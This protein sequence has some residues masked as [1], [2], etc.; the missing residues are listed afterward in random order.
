MNVTPFT[1]QRKAAAMNSFPTPD[2][3]RARIQ[4]E[5]GDVH[6]DSGDAGQT[7]V[8]VVPADPSDEKDCRDAEATRVTFTEGR[9]EVI[10]P[11]HRGL[12]S[13]RRSGSVRVSVTLPTGSDLQTTVV[14]G[15]IH[16]T[17]SLG[18]VSAKTSAGDVGLQDAAS[19]DLRSGYG[20]V[21]AGHIGGD[22]RCSTGSGSIHIERADAQVLVKNSNGDT[23]VGDGGRS[24][25]VKAANGD[26]T[27]GHAHG[28]LVATTANGN[29]RIGC[30]ER[31]QVMLRTGMGRIHLGIPHG[32][33]ARLDLRTGYGTVS[34]ELETTSEPEPSERTIEVSAATGAGDI[35]VVRAADV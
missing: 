27:V 31:G 2:P 8:D 26:V 6:V 4:I 5:L 35:D 1:E 24:V 15:A 18:A 11:R 29:V 10:G 13:G 33:V 14:A 19:A 21:A 9:L 30:V 7:L 12:G 23:W 34:S 17:G 20:S 3:I 16:L 25:R 32:T 22:L 28:D